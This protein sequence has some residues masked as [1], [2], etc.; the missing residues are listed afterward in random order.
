MC[1]KG[2]PG[3]GTGCVPA[4][5]WLH[6]VVEDSVKLS[7]SELE[8]T[9]EVR[10]VG[11]AN[12]DHD[13]LALTHGEVVGLIDACIFWYSGCAI[14]CRHEADSGYQVTLHRYYIE[15]VEVV[16]RIHNMRQP[17]SMRVRLQYDSGSIRGG[18]VLKITPII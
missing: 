9:V 7:E 1:A 10:G 4:E 3:Q 2:L 11:I 8:A 15:E 6:V 14:N 16:V 17:T 5:L 13:M 18:S 12:D